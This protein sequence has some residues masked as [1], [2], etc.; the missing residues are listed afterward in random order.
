MLASDGEDDGC[1]IEVI[2]GGWLG[3]GLLAAHDINLLD[4]SGDPTN[5]R[6]YQPAVK[7]TPPGPCNMHSTDYVPARRE[8]F[9]FGGGT[10]REHLNDLHLLH[11]DTMSGER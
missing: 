5:L 6:W 3:S 8:V 10:G 11:V 4:V 9:V 1:I 7:G 2:I